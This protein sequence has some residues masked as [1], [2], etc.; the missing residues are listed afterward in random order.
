MDD[1]VSER[2]QGVSQE[3]V[4]HICGISQ[5]LIVAGMILYQKGLNLSHKN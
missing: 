3:F 1:V 5:P 2:S 4:F